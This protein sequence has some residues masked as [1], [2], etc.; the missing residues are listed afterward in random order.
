MQN[1]IEEYRKALDIPWGFPRR[2]S[3]AKR[4]LDFLKQHLQNAP[5]DIDALCTAASVL[6]EE[7]RFLEAKKILRDFIH[8]HEDDCNKK[9]LARVATNLARM[10]EETDQV[11]TA[12]EWYKKA[13]EWGCEYSH[14][15]RAYGRYWLERG[16]YVDAMHMFTLA[17]EVGDTAED[18]YHKGLLSYRLKDYA[19]SALC[20]KLA[21]ERENKP[22]Y[23]Q[24]LAACYL[25]LSQNDAAIRLLATQAA[26]N[27]HL[28]AA[29]Y[30]RLNQY[31]HY[32]AYFSQNQQTVDP[33]LLATY[34][35]AAKQINQWQQAE[36]RYE[37]AKQ[38]LVLT[39]QKISHGMQEEEKEDDRICSKTILR[40]CQMDLETLQ[41]AFRQV[42]LSNKKPPMEIQLPYDTS[43]E[44]IDCIKRGK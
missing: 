32:V 20:M 38:W 39:I 21:M 6:M 35:Y 14:P 3:A 43:C 28:V 4:T 36:E 18:W 2:K 11:L 37:T 1:H 31:E 10:C 7:R 9:D 5:C 25:A 13:V 12:L 15:Y 26:D 24:A 30:Y 16:R 41:K 27:D 23:Q 34:F 22:L 40:Q 19:S 44:Y 17:C 8:E 29:M 42:S 33:N